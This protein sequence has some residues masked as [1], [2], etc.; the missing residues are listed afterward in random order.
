MFWQVPEVQSYVAADPKRRGPWSSSLSTGI[1][2]RVCLVACLI[3]EKQK[4]LPR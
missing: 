1:K 3:H 4:L 2:K